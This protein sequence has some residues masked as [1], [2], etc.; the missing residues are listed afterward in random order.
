MESLRMK[1]LLYDI[2]RKLTKTSNKIDKYKYL[3]CEE[4]LPPDSIQIIEQI[5]FTYS[6]PG[7]AHEKQKD[8][9]Q[10]IK[11]NRSSKSFK[12]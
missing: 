7:V 9:R 8:R 1:N 5:V 2:Y 4:I 6:P 11:T 12:N 10:K 3:K